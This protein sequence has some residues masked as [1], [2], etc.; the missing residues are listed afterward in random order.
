MQADSPRPLHRRHWRAIKL[1]LAQIDLRASAVARSPACSPARLARLAAQEGSPLSTLLYPDC[2][3]VCL[4]KLSIGRPP[5]CRHSLII[6][7][8]QAAA[9]PFQPNDRLPL[10]LSL[11]LHKDSFVDK[12]NRL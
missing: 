9:A 5:G 8:L 10:L 11:H 2:P 7:W 3:F 6:D 4:T 1:A 12:D